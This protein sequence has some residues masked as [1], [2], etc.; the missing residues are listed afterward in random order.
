MESPEPF[1]LSSSLPPCGFLKTPLLLARP[2]AFFRQLQYGEVCSRP[3]EVR[4]NSASTEPA[5]SL[6]SVRSSTPF[7]TISLTI[8]SYLQRSEENRLLAVELRARQPDAA[9]FRMLLKLLNPAW[10]S[11]LSKGGEGL[12]KNPISLFFHLNGATEGRATP[13]LKG[14]CNTATLPAM[15]R[16]T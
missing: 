13:C 4:K 10:F 6:M 14:S 12:F 16:E 1:F 11:S 7:A 8:G 2:R 9:T 3:C 5:F 15:A